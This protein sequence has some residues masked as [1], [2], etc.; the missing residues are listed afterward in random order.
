VL[1]NPHV[2]TSHASAAISD[3]R[4][5][6]VMRPRLTRPTTAEWL[7]LARTARMLSWLTLGWLG[8]EAGIA[9][10]AAVTAGSVALLGFGLDSGIEAPASIIV[11]CRFTWTRLGARPRNRP[12]RRP[13]GLGSHPRRQRRHTRHS[14]P[15]RP[16]P[17]AIRKVLPDFARSLAA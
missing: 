2:A 14:P 6:F 8:A 5:G 17:A 3:D 16:T 11:I 15:S 12:R 10:G 4:Q 1:E 7:R 13:A 9:V